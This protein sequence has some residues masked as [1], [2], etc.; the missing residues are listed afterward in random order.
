VNVLLNDGGGHFQSAI[1]YATGLS[2]PSGVAIGDFNG[3]GKADLAVTASTN[4]ASVLLNNGN[5]TFGPAIL[6]ATNYPADSVAVGDFNR[7]GKADLA[8]GIENSFYLYTVYDWWYEYSYDVYETDVGM[9][10]LEGNGDGT[11][12]AETDVFTNSY[13][14]NFSPVSDPVA[15]LAV[16]DFEHDGFPDI[17][18]IES[19]GSAD[20]L[21]NAS[22]RAGLQMAVSPASATAGVARSVTVSAFDLSGNP[23]PAYT[24]TVH[25]TSSD[26]QAVL[27]ADYSFTAADHGVH[28]FSVT[29]DTAG[30]QSLSVADYKAFAFASADVTVSP[31][32][33]SAFG[34]GGPYQPS[35]GATAFM[36]VVVVDPY[37]NLAT[38]YTGTAHFSSSDAAATL[39]ADYTFTAADGGQH[40][41]PVILR[42]A[43]PQTL[44]ATDTHAPAITG[45]GTTDVLPAASL[46][47]PTV[48]SIYQDLTFT[49]TASGGASASTVYNFE[50]D[51]NGDGIVDQ[52]LSGVSGTTVTQS[53]ASMGTTTIV[54]T[55]SVNG[56]TSVP[57][58]TSVNIGPAAAS[59]FSMAGPASAVSSGQA[60]NVT[61]TA[62][63]PY[64]NVATGYT[65]TVHFSSSAAATLPADYTFTVADGG[66]HTFSVILRS[67]G[68]QTVTATDTHA[69][70]L[71]GQ[72]AVNVLPV[73]SVS[74]PVVGSVNQALTFALS[75]S[76]GASASTVYTFQLDWNG[77]GIVDQTLSGVSGTALTHSFAS[78]GT[79]TVILRASVNGTTSAPAYATVNIVGVTTQIGTDPGDPTRQALFVTN[80]TGNDSIILSPGPGNGLNFSYNGIALGN[81]TPSGSLP[82]SHLIVYGSAGANVI[83]LTGGLAV[84]A[85]L[86]GG[87]GGDTLDAAGSTVA[88]V[89]VGGAGNDA[90]SGGSGNDILIGG[91]G[92]DLLHGNGG[93]DILIGGTTS[94]DT[95][96]AALCAVSREWGRSDVS[97]SGRINHLKGGAGGLN[98]SYVLTTATV[99]DD[100][101]TDNLYGDTGSDWFFARISGSSWHKD[102][103]QDRSST[104]VL[105]SL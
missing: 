2:G 91:L 72:T 37:G 12:A 83:R 9:G 95:N 100:G 92:S 5:G 69:P 55:A 24:G 98:G 23:D 56:L 81:A 28:T 46:S 32:A 17:A 85:I 34:I 74:G 73:A 21:L 27:P 75:A 86:F 1:A 19:F 43:G 51:W 45:E 105:T 76:G 57:A 96:L 89:L 54:L 35:S 15:A 4:A 40:N 59:T 39:P 48:G 63:D 29:L 79:F 88:N 44:T 14:S 53:F 30:T 11:F 68:S 47:G 36:A 41:F 104:E 61:L 101:V 6:Y 7:D 3:D 18:G 80:T 78:G 66:V 84:P 31:A 20:V 58:S 64:G 97:Y 10:F 71:T 102:R 33:A 8:M 25:F 26:Y 52:T 42:T 65:G 49:L 82:F 62:M 93:D 77:D 70:A 38:D 94:Y 22:P 99:F 90:L 103:V 60:F 87:G 50:L 67:A 16:G 13:Q